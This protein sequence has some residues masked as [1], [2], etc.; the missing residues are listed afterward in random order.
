MLPGVALVL[1]GGGVLGQAFHVGVL[2]ALAEA[3][4]DPRTAD[5]VVGTSAGSQVG[6]VLRAGVSG[7]DLAAAVAG[8]PMTPSGAALIAPVTASA[9]IPDPGPRSRSG[10]WRSGLLGQLATRPTEARLGVL[11]A[12]VLP[13]GRRPTE[14]FVAGFDPV[15]GSDWPDAP[16]WTPATD[17]ATGRRVVFGRAGAPRATVGQAVAASCAVPGFFAPA[18]IDGRRYADGG[19]H[20]CLNLDLL[21]EE[22]LGDVVA[23]APLSF[24]G[25]PV[26]GS[27]RRVRMWHR[28]EV[29]REVRLVRRS[30]SRVTVFQPGP[31]V[32]RAWG[33]NA[34]DY[35]HCRAV[36]EAARVQA[37]RQLEDGA[38]PWLA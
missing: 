6:A 33:R 16:L 38:A 37:W 13:E 27:G 35:D 14:R 31:A 12:A 23:C 28:L 4:W 3:G 20:S 9:G 8:D 26:S 36:V 2:A 22:G 19:C 5:L 34:M 1:G 29:E 30:G 17:L 18:V 21:A 15:F 10:A 25:T 24:G 7:P 11:L 32:Q